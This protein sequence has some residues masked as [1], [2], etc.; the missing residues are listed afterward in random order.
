MGTETTFF[1]NLTDREHA[2]RVLLDQTHQ[3]AARLRA[4]DR[5]CRVAVLKARGADFTTVT[6]AYGAAR[7][8]GLTVDTAALT[9]PST[10]IDIGQ[11][12]LEAEVLELEC[13]HQRAA[14]MGAGRA[15][16]TSV[17]IPII[18]MLIS[19]LV[20]GYR[21]SPLAITGALLAIAGMAI[22][23]RAKAA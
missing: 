13:I 10:N 19:T 14:R 11:R 3:C 21:W 5:R 20:E 15:A 16:Y 6:R 8:R 9:R 2:R 1:E 22:A 18:A 4:A 12:H 7:E 17:L 23:L